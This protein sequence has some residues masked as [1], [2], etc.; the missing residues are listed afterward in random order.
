M[1]GY[2]KVRKMHF[3]T[4]WL[5]CNFTAINLHLVVVHS[6]P[7]GFPGPSLAVTTRRSS[8][9]HPSG[10]AGVCCAVWCCR[11]V[12]CHTTALALLHHTTPHHWHCYT[13]PHHSTGSATPQG[14]NSDYTY[15]WSD[16]S[17]GAYKKPLPIA[18]AEPQSPEINCKLCKVFGRTFWDIETWPQLMVNNF[19]NY[20]EFH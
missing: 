6:S 17:R 9:A 1:Q 18:G 13:T 8:S 15:S 14:R 10:A 7:P 16:H 5:F 19:C 12:W 20:T 2:L 3:S 11:G 4:F